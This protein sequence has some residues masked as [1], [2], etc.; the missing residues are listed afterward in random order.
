MYFD[1]S[2]AL[3]FKTLNEMSKEKSLQPQI[4]TH[5]DFQPKILMH[6]DLIKNDPT[7]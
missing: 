2:D 7:L 3:S 6:L 1:W 5:L 4:L